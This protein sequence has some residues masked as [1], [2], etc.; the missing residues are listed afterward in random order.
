MARQNGD[1]DCSG[2]T[3]CDAAIVRRTTFSPTV[4]NPGPERGD[5]DHTVEVEVQHESGLAT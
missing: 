4:I 2:K 1:I 5:M 3:Y